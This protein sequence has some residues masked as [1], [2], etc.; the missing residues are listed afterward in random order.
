MAEEIPLQE[1]RNRN[2]D[3]RDSDH[4]D[5]SIRRRSID[6]GDREDHNPKIDVNSIAGLVTILS[7]NFHQLE[8]LVQVGPEWGFKF[9]LN[10]VL[11]AVSIACVYWT[12]FG[13]MVAIFSA[14]LTLQIFDDVDTRCSILLNQALP[15][16][17]NSSV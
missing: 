7:V 13:L 11:V 8:S 3:R 12:S 6:S 10:I 15:P 14:N 17:S 16:S 9:W 2:G 1:F 5:L 4:R